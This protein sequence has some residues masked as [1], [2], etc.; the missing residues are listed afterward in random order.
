MDVDAEDEKLPDLHGDLAAGERD[1]TGEGN[2]FRKR[3]GGG[4]CGG[5]EIFEEGGLMRREVS[6]GIK[7][8]KGIGRFE[9]AERWME[10]TLGF[11]IP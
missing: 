9:R 2:L 11:G 10:R 4:Y 6:G 3:R 1:G 5:N 8:V 7:E